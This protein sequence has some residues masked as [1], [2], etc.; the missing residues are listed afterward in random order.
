MRRPRAHGLRRPPLEEDQLF[1]RLSELLGREVSPGDEIGL[2]LVVGLDMS[3]IES[4]FLTSRNHTI[5]LSA[6]L[7]LVGGAAIYFL[8]IVQHYRSTRT[9]LA[10]MRSYTTNVIESMPS[11]LVS[12]DAGGNVVTLNS[13]ARSLLGVTE[14]D[15]K[16]RPVEEVVTIEAQP[17]R[18]AVEDIVGGRESVLET[19]ARMTV[20]DRTIPVAL[21]ASSLRDEDGKRAGTVLLFQDQREVEALKAEVER[22]RHLASLGRLSAGVAHEIRNPLSSLK[23]FAQFLRSRFQPGSQ[24]ERYSDIM[25]EEVERLDRVVQELLD[26]AKPNEPARAASSANEIVDDALSL[27]SEDAAFRNVEIRREFAPDLPHVFVD[28]KQI[29][30]AVLNVVLNG[31][32]AMPGGGV[33]TVRTSVSRNQRGPA[34][35]S[36][37]VSDTGE[38]MDEEQLSKL[39]E[40]FYT[41]KQGGTGL[42]LTIVSRVLEQNGGHVEVTSVKGGGTAFSLRLPLESRED[43]KER[44]SRSE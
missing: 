19:D 12:L 33:L 16:G 23:G 34:Y 32:E 37:V 5:M 9:A 31:I 6:V 26:F 21:S 44:V 17:G 36:V 24:E 25:I 20:G 35:V 29:M 30:Q 3:D 11:G 4:A 27:L 15:V 43:S 8:F 28:P 40:P 2:R 10:N 7:L 1:G 13:T 41:T 39:Y 42:G 38:G 18:A 14:S 22:E